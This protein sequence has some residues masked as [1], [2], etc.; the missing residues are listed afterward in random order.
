MGLLTLVLALASPGMEQ[1]FDASTASTCRDQRINSTVAELIGKWSQNYAF[2]R[3]IIGADGK[4][5]QVLS[6]TMITQGP[7]YI[8]CQASYRVSKAGTNVSMMSYVTALTRFTFRVTPTSAGYT[9]ALEDLPDHLDG[10]EEQAAALIA[11]FTVN[12]RPYYAILQENKRRT[13]AK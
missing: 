3:V 6:P 11:R 2:S 13:T 5:G 7:G 8:I 12:G 10:S 4:F 1:Q 9:I